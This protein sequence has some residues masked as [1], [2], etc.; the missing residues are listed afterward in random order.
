LPAA[1]RAAEEAVDLA[2]K[3]SEKRQLSNAFAT[4]SNV[5]AADGDLDQAVELILAAIDLS[6]EIGDARG[7]L[8]GREIL[9]CTYR[10]LGRLDEAYQLMRDQVPRNLQFQS[11]ESLMILAED[12]G[13]VL[14]DLGEH[15]LAVRLLGAADA[16]RQRHVHPRSP[17]QE[18]EI[19]EPF[20][21]ARAALG[22]RDW[23]RAYTRGN[24]MAVEDALAEGHSAERL[25]SARP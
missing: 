20:A 6:L 5:V 24:N 14:A 23:D 21:R 15:D 25:P 2:R 18:T 17:S 9:A 11:P 3:G 10:E 22:P 12:F 1:R 19:H 7:V 8:I 4:L 16:M 13:A